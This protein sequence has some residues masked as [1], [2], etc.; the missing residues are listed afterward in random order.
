MRVEIITHIKNLIVVANREIIDVDDSEEEGDS[1][2]SAGLTLSDVPRCV[3]NLKVHA[4]GFY[5]PIV[6]GTL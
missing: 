5:A 3:G 4:K 2:T 6:Q 1:D